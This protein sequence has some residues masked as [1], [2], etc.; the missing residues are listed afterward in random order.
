[1]PS[2]T[3]LAVLA[4]S[5]AGLLSHASVLQREAADQNLKRQAPH[6]E[7]PAGE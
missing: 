1:M 3:A 2:L 5:C 6:E 4:L 7:W